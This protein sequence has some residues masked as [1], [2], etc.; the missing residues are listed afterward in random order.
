MSLQAVPQHARVLTQE[1][2]KTLEE[3]LGALATPI[4]NSGTSELEAGHRL[5]VQYVLQMLRRGW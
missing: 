3:K 4:V 1:Q 2:Y 5:G